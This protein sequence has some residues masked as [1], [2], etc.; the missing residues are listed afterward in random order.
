MEFDKNFTP[1]AGFRSLIGDQYGDWTVVSFAGRVVT[2][3]THTYYWNCVDSLGNEKTIASTNL[4]SGWAAGHKLD[5]TGK[6]TGTKKSLKEM[7][8]KEYGFLKVIDT[9]SKGGWWLTE[10]SNCGRKTEKQTGNILKGMT[11]TCG[12][13]ECTK[14]WRRRRAFGLEG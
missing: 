1:R 6:G 11:K 13:K 4:K 2:N 3:K 5:R 7:R 8:S 9:G 14:A 12:H 10:C